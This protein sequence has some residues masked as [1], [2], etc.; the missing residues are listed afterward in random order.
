MS[1]ATSEETRAAFADERQAAIARLVEERGRARVTE[2]AESFGVSSVTIRKDLDVL[3]DHGRVIRTHGGAIAPRVRGQ[4]LAYDVRDRMQQAEKAAIGR[5]A[6][7]RVRDGESIIVDAS[8]TSL[9]LARELMQRTSGQSLTI[10]TNSIRLATELAVRPD[11]SVLLMGGR[12][13][14]RSLSLVG[15]LGDGVLRR[16][17][18]HKAF[19]G[20]AG[21]T[22]EDG[23]TETTEEEAQIKR[24]MVA[25]A[26]EVYALVDNSKWGRVASA[27][28]CRPEDLTG[29]FTDAGAP[30][31]MVEGLQGMGIEV[32]QH[33]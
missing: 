17:N 7:T 32:L 1:P 16:V 22:A 14:G 19:V 21:L 20:A 26:R 13:R 10:V 29:V 4:D 15:Q 24:A 5:L 25:A 6:A 11:I 31:D 8:T 28:F 27:T 30:G 23:L 12:V 18:V 33:G 3:A 2:L 9:Y